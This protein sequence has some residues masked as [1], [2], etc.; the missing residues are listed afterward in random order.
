MTDAATGST[1]K[2]LAEFGFN[3]FEFKAAV[4]EETVDV[5]W[6][7]PNFT[8][9]QERPSHS[10]IPILFPFPGR[11]PGTTFRW[12]SRDYQLPEGDGIGNAIHGFVLDRPWRVIEQSASR[13]VGQFQASEDDVSLLDR[14]PADFRIT[15]SYEVAGA[16]LISQLT[17][18]NP[19][20]KPL[21]CGLG[22]HPYF[23]LPLGTGDASDCVVSLPVTEQWQL[24]DML[25][26][27]E[28]MPVENAADF[29]HGLKFADMKFDDVFAGL[30]PD[31]DR[32]VTRISDPASGRSVVQEFDRIFRECVVYTPPHREAICIEPY[33]CLPGGFALTERGI[34][35]GVRVLTSGESLTASVTI[36]VE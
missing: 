34:D 23:R 18:E 26:N 12:E 6:S 7:V 28:R 14:W 19:D 11:I 2:V 32:I 20:K 4:G 31:G 16:S 24:A 35:T 30:R 9:G 36:R 3:C 10:G 17:I 8:S 1:A 33:T 21:P 29:H 27:G 22:T 15:V 13:V 25:P 5:L